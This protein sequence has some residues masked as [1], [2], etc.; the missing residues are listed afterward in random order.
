MTNPMKMKKQK[1]VIQSFKFKGFKNT[2]AWFFKLRFTGMTIPIPGS[3]NGK[4]KSTYKDL[5][6]N[7]VMSPIAT[8]YFCPQNIKHH[9]H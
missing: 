8:S 1:L 2:H 7:I 6:A 9:Y 4:V 5:F 3:M